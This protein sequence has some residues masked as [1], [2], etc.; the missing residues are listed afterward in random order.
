MTAAS[1]RQLGV[2]LVVEDDWLT[3]ASIVDDLTT[4]G[5]IVL[6]SSG[7]SSAIASLKSSEHIDL[8][9]I[10]TDLREELLG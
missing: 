8:L 7:A 10:D 1:N 5:C 6:E 2:V 3:R 9:F 4:A